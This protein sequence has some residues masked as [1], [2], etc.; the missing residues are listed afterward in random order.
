MN[1]IFRDTAGIPLNDNWLGVLPKNIG[2]MWQQFFDEN[3]KRS[4]EDRD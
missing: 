3:K 4:R 2:N 1:Y